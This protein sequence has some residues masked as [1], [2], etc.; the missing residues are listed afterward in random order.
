MSAQMA[1]YTAMCNVI[2]L[3]RAI[4]QNAN[5]IWVTGVNNL[6]MNAAVKMDKLATL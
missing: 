3:T 2:L 5:F 4:T 1:Q 6:S